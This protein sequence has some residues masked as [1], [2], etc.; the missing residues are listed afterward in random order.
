M[1][2]WEYYIHTTV[3]NRQLMQTYC[4]PQENLHKFVI[5]YMGEKN[6]YIYIKTDYLCCTPETNATL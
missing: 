6:G 1:G 2:G 3:K 4:I 5:N